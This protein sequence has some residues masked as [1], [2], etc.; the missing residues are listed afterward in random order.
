MADTPSSRIGVL[1]IEV[2]GEWDI[3]DLR[4]LAESLSDTYGLFYPVI[5]TDEETTPRL[6]NQIRRQFWSGDT[7]SRYIGRHLYNSIPKKESL[8]LKSFHYSSP[9]AFEIMGVVA[10]LLM[11]SRVARSWIL[12]ASGFID[13][14]EK[15]ERFFNRRKNLKRPKRKLA[16][17]DEMAF[18]SDEARVLVFEIGPKLGFDALSCERLI[19]IVGNPISTLKFLVAIGREGRKLADLQSNGLLELPAP[20]DGIITIPP[21]KKGSGSTRGDGIIVVKK[22]RKRKPATK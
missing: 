22:S 2:D 8:R 4:D 7:D 3:S 19:A 12:T 6:H 17:D 5:S 13:C 20:P 1:R 9:G 16:L 21:P 11:M 10:C 14:W 18:N 15:V